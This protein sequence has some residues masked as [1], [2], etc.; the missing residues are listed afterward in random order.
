MKNR[1]EHLGD[2]EVVRKEYDHLHL[3]TIDVAEAL[4]EPQ[5]GKPCTR[6]KDY[7]VGRFSWSPDGSRIAFDATRNPDLIHIG[8]ADIYVLN[9]ADLAVKKIVSQPGPDGNPHWSPD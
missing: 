4:K 5:T 1:K 8:S 3:W 7:S 6:G 9:L 2:F